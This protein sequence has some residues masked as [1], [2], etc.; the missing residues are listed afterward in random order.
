MELKKSLLNVRRITSE[1]K[2]QIIL[3]EII[4]TLNRLQNIKVNDD[5][6]HVN[7]FAAK[8]LTFISEKFS[9]K[10]S[11]IQK[12]TLRQEE[13]GKSLKPKLTERSNGELWK[14]GNFINH[15]VHIIDRKN[16]EKSISAFI[17]FCEFGGNFSVGVKIQNFSMP[18]CNAFEAFNTLKFA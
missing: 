11:L 1:I 9:L 12:L 7:I 3:T 2:E 8:I 4:L 17:P 6:K 18:V 16:A 15:P 14:Y 5:M 10:Y 13:S